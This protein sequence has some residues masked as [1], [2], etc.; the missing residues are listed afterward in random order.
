MPIYLGNKE[1]NKEYVDSYESGLLYLGSNI[2]QGNVDYKVSD[3][4]LVAY[5]DISNPNCYTSGSTT[6][7]DL[8]ANNN[9]MTIGDNL[10]YSPNNS[11]ILV[12]NN[13]YAYVTPSNGTPSGS[14][15]V[16]PNLT[17]G[18][19]AKYDN[20]GTSTNPNNAF[21]FG[22]VNAGNPGYITLTNISSSTN[23]DFG[24]TF[25]SSFPP[26]KVRSIRVT[27]SFAT[28]SWYNI[29]VS[30]SGSTDVDTSPGI[31]SVYVNGQFIGSGSMSMVV[32][33]QGTPITIGVPNG[34][35][36]A[37]RG[38]GFY[39]SFGVGYI[40]NRLMNANEIAFNWNAQKN[41]FGQ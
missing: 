1:I 21:S 27:S 12:G 41:R 38:N 17:F 31:A 29:M 14:G 28:G 15:V 5:Y 32:S 2:V 9:D 20:F 39:G 26:Q 4:G 30:Y 3:L 37:A 35:D 22:S 23:L 40:Y 34:A 25:P 16:Q 8:T 10:I 7:F 18:F 6:I 11:G 19:W 13:A 33:E 36:P 24:S